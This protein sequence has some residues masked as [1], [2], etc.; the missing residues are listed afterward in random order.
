MADLDRQWHDLQARVHAAMTR[1]E[2][3][4]GQ[5]AGNLAGRLTGFLSEFKNF[6]IWT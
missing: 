2:S 5:T 6:A 3:L 1:D 4:P